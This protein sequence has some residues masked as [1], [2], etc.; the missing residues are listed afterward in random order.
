MRSFVVFLLQCTTGWRAGITRRWACC[1]DTKPWRPTL[2]PIEPQTSGGKAVSEA[3]L[4]ALSLRLQLP[5]N[6]TT[7]PKMPNPS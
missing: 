6:L 7:T 2:D 3:G 4:H 1:S 5:L